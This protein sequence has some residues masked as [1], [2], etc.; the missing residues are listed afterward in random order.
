MSRPARLSGLRASDTD[1]GT[2]VARLRA[3]WLEGRLSLPEFES[4]VSSA[5]TCRHHGELEELLADLPLPALPVP[6]LAG[7]WRRSVALV[8][9]H[10][11]FAILAAVAVGVA[12]V[13]GHA[14]VGLALTPLALPV[15]AIGYYTAAHGSRSGRSIGERICGIAV[16]DDPFRTHVLQRA[17]HGQA[18]G[19]ALMLYL[20]AASSLFGVGLLN[21]LWPI[22]DRK[23]QAWHDE[24]AG[25]L[26]VRAPSMAFERRKWS[27]RFRAAWAAL[28]HG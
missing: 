6:P 13:T 9:D 12:A 19:R 7:W 23:K 11:L 5:L 22:W 10:L 15:V 1:R 16:R 18:F 2:A 20:F 14:D 3:A 28:R 25:T 4:R 17:S 8:V 24:L 21:F 26:V 27:R